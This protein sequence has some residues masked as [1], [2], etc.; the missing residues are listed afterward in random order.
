[1]TSTWV[2]AQW[3]SEIRI[4]QS[5][6]DTDEFVEVFTSLGTLSLDGYTYLVIEA[7][8]T[9]QAVVM[10]A[11]DLAGQTIPADG[12][13]VMGEST[14]T[15]TTPDFV[16]DLLFNDDVN[17][18]HAMVTGFSGQVGDVLDPDLSLIPNPPWSE[19]R[20][21]ITV[22]N[23]LSLGWTPIC[24]DSLTNP[25]GPIAH[26]GFCFDLHGGST[27]LDV[28]SGRDT[29]GRLVDPCFPTF[30][31]PA[32]P[33][34]TGT[35]TKLVRDV[36]PQSP[37]RIRLEAFDGPPQQFG[38]MLVGTD[39][40]QSP[41]LL[42]EGWFC[43][44][45]TAGQEFGRYNV[46]QSPMNSI[47]VFDSEGVFQNLVG[48]NSVSSGFDL[49]LSLPFQTPTTIQSGE[50]LHFQLWYRDQ[51]SGQSVSN[52]SSGVSQYFF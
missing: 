48:T 40:A 21:C 22:L 15:L 34:S 43:L 35:H 31:D 1:M 42:S 50:T 32:L 36:S 20:Y 49:P 18:T 47:G 44:G 28:S 41:L 5:G 25:Q 7:N 23:D 24:G 33:N 16:T 12:Y 9:G 52:F 26:V 8:A 4:A 39:V 51:I 11:I 27:E 19:M 46:P 13:F 6:P 45:Y 37:T 17:V 3:I 14:L 38:Y 30:C 29:P 2:Q 10:Q